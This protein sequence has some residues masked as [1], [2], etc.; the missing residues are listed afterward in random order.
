MG[1]PEFLRSLVSDASAL[2]RR[3]KAAHAADDRAALSTLYL[4]A[5]ELKEAE[6]DI[7][8]ACF[9][10]TQAY[11]FGLDSRAVEA[12]DLAHAKLVRYGRE[13]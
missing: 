11:V 13:Q 3:I 7:A 6:G 9:L 2:D 10:Y 5:G 4:K 1:G 8:A 12:R